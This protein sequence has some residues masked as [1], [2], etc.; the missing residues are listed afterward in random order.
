MFKRIILTCLSFVILAGVCLSTPQMEAEAAFN[1]DYTPQSESV[2]FINMDTG[3]VVYEKNAD[4]R[5]YPAST[6]KVMTALLAIELC[7]DL[8][9]MVTVS[10]KV[11]SDLMNTDSS[12]SGIMARERLSML[13]LLHCLMLPSGNDAALAIAYYLGDGDVNK[14]VDIMNER[15]QEMG[16]VNTHFENPHGLHDPDHYTTARDLAKISQEA[17]ELPAFAEIVQKR[18]YYVE[19]TNK[20]GRRL[21]INTNHLLNIN[22]STS[23]YYTYCKGIKTG[24]TSKAGNCF[25]AYATRQGYNYIC[26]CLKAPIYDAKGNTLAFNGSFIDAKELFDWAFFNLS[27]MEVLPADAAVAEVD[28]DLTWNKDKLA[29]VPEQSFKT[30]LPSKV[31][32]TSVYREISIPK[33][34]AAPI[35]KGQVIGTVTLKYADENLGTVNLI[36]S[37]SVERNEFLYILSILNDVVS[38]TAFIVVVFILILMAVIYVL[39]SVYF[40]KN[41]KKQRVRRYR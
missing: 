31:K 5:R 37:E 22:F 38:S 27:L 36:A 20:Q 21:L 2:F 30:L 41:K 29:L 15:A 9:T 34:V 8:S 33:S 40:N 19:A 26:V 17:M 25:T 10:D 24:R 18:T 1:I 14:F 12:R 39:W 35:E 11:M 32:S 3:I 6:T 16:C 23:Y 28:L 7:P 4:E 13:D